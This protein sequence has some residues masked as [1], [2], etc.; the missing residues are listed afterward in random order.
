MDPKD[1]DL[2]TL[3]LSAQTRDERLR[4]LKSKLE[5]NPGETAE[6]QE[7]LA[8]RIKLLE[9]LGAN[10]NRTCRL[11]SRLTKTEVTLSPLLYDPYHIRG[12][13]LGVRV[14]NTPAILLLD[15]GAS[16]FLVSSRIA[17]KA[18]L[19]EDRL[20]AGRRNRRPRCV[21]RLPGICGQNK[22]RGTG[23]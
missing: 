5:G 23:I 22:N 10:P 3:W 8:Q 13:G 4:D 11:V 12:Y 2:E 1:P 21:E 16:G 15:T 20:Y 7:N 17:E 9:D 6:E 19:R 18:G 14:N